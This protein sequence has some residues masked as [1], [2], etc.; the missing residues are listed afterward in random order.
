MNGCKERFAGTLRGDFS[1]IRCCGDYRAR[2]R[3]LMYCC[4]SILWANALN[5]EFTQVRVKQCYDIPSLYRFPKGFRN[6]RRE[7]LRVGI[8]LMLDGIMLGQDIS[9]RVSA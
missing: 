7:P 8:T 3:E 2:L 1:V 4:C 6:G 5:V 9:Q